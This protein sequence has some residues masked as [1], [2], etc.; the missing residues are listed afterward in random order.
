MEINLDSEVLI[1]AR[2]GDKVFELS[3][4]TVKQ[5]QSFQKKMKG[6]DDMEAYADFLAD[7]GLPKD[8]TENLGISKLKKISDGLLGSFEKK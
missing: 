4:P 6:D 7:L 8:I 1:K 5:V 3:E 2:L